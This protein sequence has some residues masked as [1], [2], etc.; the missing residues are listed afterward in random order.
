[1]RRALRVPLQHSVSNQPGQGLFEWEISLAVDCLSPVG[2]TRQD[3]RPRGYISDPDSGCEQLGQG[4]D[5]DGGLFR[6]RPCG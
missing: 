3:V 5:I 2:Y 4:A 1:M 6:V